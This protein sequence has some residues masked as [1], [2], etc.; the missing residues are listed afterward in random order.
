MSALVLP[1]IVGHGCGTVTPPRTGSDERRRPAVAALDES[2]SGE[3]WVNL[4]TGTIRDM[5]RETAQQQLFRANA[6]IQQ[7]S[8]QVVRAR[9]TILQHDLQNKLLKIESQELA[10]RHQVERAIARREIDILR[11]DHTRADAPASERETAAVV[12]AEVYRRRLRQ[13]KLRLHETQR[14]LEERQ[15]EVESLRPRKRTPKTRATRTGKPREAEVARTPAHVT[16]AGPAGHVT[17]PHEDGL[18]ALGMLASQVLSQ[19]P[20]A[21]PATPRQG[22]ETARRMSLAAITSS[23]PAPSPL[24]PRALA[25]SSASSDARTLSRADTDDERADDTESDR[26]RTPGDSPALSL[27]QSVFRHPDRPLPAGDYL[28]SPSAEPRSPDWVRSTPRSLLAATPSRDWSPVTTT[29]GTTPGVPRS[30]FFPSAVSSTG[31]QTVPVSRSAQYLHAL[32]M[33]ADP[34]RPDHLPAGRK[35]RR[36]SSDSTIS[37]TTVDRPS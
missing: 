4:S 33:D 7:L 23:S 34:D 24:V 16:H 3:D 31:G 5:D 26:A 9:S 35:R 1:P 15:A 32:H 11:L 18:A 22:A 14:Q 36:S 29:P 2:E 17:A 25:P 20:L 19:G 13:A 6:H 10:Q 8:L 27:L 37:S 28:R 30:T 21:S 12:A